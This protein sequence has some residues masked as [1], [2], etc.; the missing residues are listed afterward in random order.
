MT[1]IE[2]ENFKILPG[3]FY[4]KAFIKEYALAVGLDPAELIEMYQ[5]DVPEPEENQEQQYTRIQ[6]RKESNPQK[7]NAI[8]SLIPMIIVVVLI[9]G[10]LFAGWYFY[11]Q[12]ISKNDSGAET[13]KDD[14]EIII[15]GPDDDDPNDAETKDEN[16]DED[17]S[18]AAKKRC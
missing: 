5:E 2:E 11:K 8:F 6:S 15:N 9:I 14:N 12:N 3:T 18:D 4:A 7:S 17:S 10:I 16:G 13:P 1:A